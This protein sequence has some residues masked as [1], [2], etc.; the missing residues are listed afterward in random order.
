MNTQLQDICLSQ[1][2]PI[3]RPADGSDAIE[4][5]ATGDYPMASHWFRIFER[6]NDQVGVILEFPACESGESGEIDRVDRFCELVTENFFGPCAR[7][8]FNSVEKRFFLAALPKKRR[9]QVTSPVWPTGAMLQYPYVNLS[10]VKAGGMTQSLTWLSST[11][12]NYFRLK[13]Y[14]SRT[15][16]GLHFLGPL[17]LCY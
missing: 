6:P 5:I 7:L 11:R 3:Y 1:G 12:W 9:L 8:H 16:E 4:V 15:R 17:L 13:I 14:P 10:V 2:L